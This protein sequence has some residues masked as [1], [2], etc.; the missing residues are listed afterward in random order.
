MADVNVNFI[1][2]TDGRTMTVNLD[3]SITAQEAVAELI[4]A[5]FITPN[6]HGYGLAIK[7]GNMI[8]P[9]QTFRNAGVQ[10]SEK[11]TIRVVPATDAG[12]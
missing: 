11:N 12:I 9:G 8:Q 10:E 3:D 5:D 2:P 6:P 1:H 4:S 7:G